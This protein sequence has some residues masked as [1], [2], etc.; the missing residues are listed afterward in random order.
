MLYFSKEKT[1]T[2]LHKVYIELF[3]IHVGLILGHQLSKFSLF[4]KMI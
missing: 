2:K 4:E 3:F 1:K